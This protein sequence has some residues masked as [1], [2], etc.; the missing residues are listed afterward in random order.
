MAY[1]SLD[2][3]LLKGLCLICIDLF[4]CEYA[5][6]GV[7]RKH[8]RAKGGSHLNGCMKLVR[9]WHCMEHINSSPPSATTT[10][11]TPPLSVHP[12]LPLLS[13]LKETN[14]PLKTHHS[15]QMMF[16]E[17]LMTVS[18]SACALTSGCVKFNL[19]KFSLLLSK[20]TMC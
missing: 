11:S 1:L 17:S 5:L 14:A 7:G 2:L 9:C 20:S 18:V 8:R 19:S 12:H 4:L 16:V 13:K 10:S 6:R 3:D 15:T